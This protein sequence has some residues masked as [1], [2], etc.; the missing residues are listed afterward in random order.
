[1][2]SILIR[3]P[4]IQFARLITY[5]FEIFLT[6]FRMKVLPDEYTIDKVKIKYYRHILN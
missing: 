2:Q 6:I 5:Y 1:M 4:T 3:S